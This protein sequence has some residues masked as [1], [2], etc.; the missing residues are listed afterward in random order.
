MTKKILKLKN[1]LIKKM[2][3]IKTNDKKNVYYKN[4]KYD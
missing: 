2:F 4:N 1:L 3:N